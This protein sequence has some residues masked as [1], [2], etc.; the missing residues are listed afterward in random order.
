V[1]E[2]GKKLPS[3]DA[4]KERKRQRLSQALRANLLR[5][6]EVQVKAVA[7]AIDGRSTLPEN[8]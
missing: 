4:G 2:A 3:T 5:R 7:E 8:K 1:S 6:K